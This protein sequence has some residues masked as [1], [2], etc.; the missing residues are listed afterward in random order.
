MMCTCV[1]PFKGHS[2]AEFEDPNIINEKTCIQIN[3]YM[4][5]RYINMSTHMVKYTC[6][7][8][9]LFWR[10][11]C[12]SFGSWEAVF[13][14]VDPWWSYKAL[15]TGVGLEKKKTERVRTQQL[16]EIFET[17]TTYNLRTAQCLLSGTFSQAPTVYTGE[18][19]SHVCIT[20]KYPG[21]CEHSLFLF[22]L[23]KNKESEVL[24]QHET[25]Y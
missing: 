23:G 21:C 11:F 19:I 3:K 22:K 5:I 4:Q 15:L 13:C 10:W 8:L 16:T 12:I 17:C 24:E 14:V 7:S 25:H 2:H 20:D 9:F 6:A 18:T 1:F